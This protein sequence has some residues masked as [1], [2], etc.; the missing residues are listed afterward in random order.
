MWFGLQLAR[1]VESSAVELLCAAAAFHLGL[2]KRG[3][4]WVV[5]GEKKRRRGRGKEG[6]RQGLYDAAMI[7]RHGT[8]RYA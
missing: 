5:C 2:G 8:S 6:G 3:V 7:S 4:V 1:A